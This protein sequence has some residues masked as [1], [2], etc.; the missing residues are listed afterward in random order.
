M[1]IVGLGFTDFENSSE[2]NITNNLSFTSSKHKLTELG[3]SFVL[4]PADKATNNAAM[5]F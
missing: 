3:E 4:V 5:H 1:N 2:A